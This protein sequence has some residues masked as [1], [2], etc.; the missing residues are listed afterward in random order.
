MISSHNE[1]VLKN[2]KKKTDLALVNMKMKHLAPIA[3]EKETSELKKKYREGHVSLF[4]QD[5]QR[6]LKRRHGVP[7]HGVWMYV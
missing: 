6:Q 4:I 2:Q 7:G 1:K 5:Q 3:Y